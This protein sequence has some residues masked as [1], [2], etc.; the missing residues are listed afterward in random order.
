MQQPGLPIEEAFKEVRRN[1]SRETKG[2]KSFGWA[3]G[4]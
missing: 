3:C 1:V 4:L 2:G